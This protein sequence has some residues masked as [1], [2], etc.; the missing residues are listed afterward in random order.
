MTFITYSEIRS[1]EKMI[2][3]EGFTKE[4]LIELASDN[5]NDK[6]LYL[7]HS[8]VDDEKIAGI[9]AFFFGFNA[10]AYVRSLAKEKDKTLYEK[11]DDMR[12]A[13]KSIPKTVVVVSPESC[14]SLWVP[15]KLGLVEGIKGFESVTLLPIKDDYELEDWMD[16][17]CLSLYPRIVHEFGDWVVQDPK[18]GNHWKLYRWLTM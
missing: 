4:A 3:S 13:M 12:S 9:V 7:S 5:Y 17:N 2:T 8:P 18:D 10:N 14:D 15:W 1:I 16:N 11:A 6:L